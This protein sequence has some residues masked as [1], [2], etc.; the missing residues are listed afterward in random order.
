MILH[1]LQEILLRLT[2]LCLANNTI[3]ISLVKHINYL[4]H[5]VVVVNLLFLSF[6]TLLVLYYQLYY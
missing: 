2:V 6:M 1:Y 4:R 3:V 5:M